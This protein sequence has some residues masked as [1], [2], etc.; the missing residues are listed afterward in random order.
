[1]VRMTAKWCGNAAAP[2]PVDA[3]P[4]RRTVDLYQPSCQKFVLLFTQGIG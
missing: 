3:V 1:M 2:A 4:R